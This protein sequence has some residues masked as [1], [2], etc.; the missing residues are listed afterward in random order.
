MRA[1]D[2]L[3]SRP[4]LRYTWQS[5]PSA[6]FLGSKPIYKRVKSHCRTTRILGALVLF[7][8]LGLSMTLTLSD[9]AFV[10]SEDCRGS[11]FKDRVWDVPWSFSNPHFR[12][13]PAGLGFLPAFALTF[14]LCLFK[15]WSQVMEDFRAHRE[16]ESKLWGRIRVPWTFVKCTWYVSVAV[17]GLA[18]SKR[19]KG[20]LL[21]ATTSGVCT[22]CSCISTTAGR[23][24]SSSSPS[25]RPCGTRNTCFPMVRC[26]HLRALL[27]VRY[28]LNPG[29]SSF[30]P[31]FLR[32][33][34]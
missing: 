32:S 20:V 3:S 34:L 28:P 14:G 1:T 10:I 24:R 29:L 5:P 31:C 22:P 23:S 8:W 19:Y 9:R 2:S 33:H 12:G 11:S 15:R 26:G 27:T 30:C 18:K 13:Q 16:G 6:T 4:L 17:P 25:L 21:I 7:L